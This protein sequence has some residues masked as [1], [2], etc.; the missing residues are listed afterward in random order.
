MSKYRVISGP[1][2]PAFGLNTKRCEVSLRIQSK[3][4]KIKTRNYSA[5]GH[6]SRCVILSN[7]IFLHL[8]GIKYRVTIS[9]SYVTHMG[10]VTRLL[11]SVIYGWVGLKKSNFWSYEIIEWSLKTRPHNVALVN[12]LFEK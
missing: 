5:F 3:C 1:Y 6:F 9:K 7:F 2:F 4:R 11:Q 12:L 10:R 8:F